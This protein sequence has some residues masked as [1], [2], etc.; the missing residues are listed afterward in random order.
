MCIYMCHVWCELYSTC[1]MVCVWYATSVMYVEHVMNVDCV[2][3]Y[4]WSV[5]DILHVMCIAYDA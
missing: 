2:I 4:M 5:H 3:G 1:C